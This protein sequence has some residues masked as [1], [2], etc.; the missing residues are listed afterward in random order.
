MWF[1]LVGIVLVALKL[2]GTA[3]VA[4]WSW[5]WVLAPFALAVAWWLFADA[6]GITQGRVARRIE[7]RIAKRRQR[8]I[9]S[10]R[11]GIK[12]DK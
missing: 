12:R 6:F 3:P 1:L 10:L 9:E 4:A 7:A 2:Y 5:V 8:A 11:S